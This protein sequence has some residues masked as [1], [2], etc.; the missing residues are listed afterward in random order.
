[1]GHG[2]SLK[3]TEM[4]DKTWTEVTDWKLWEDRDRNFY[5][6]HGSQKR[7][8]EDHKIDLKCFNVQ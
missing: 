8:Q 2:P 3:G 5:L 4:R 1:M 7:T 6:K